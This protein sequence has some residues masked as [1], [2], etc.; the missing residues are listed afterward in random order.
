M[1][2]VI[3][4]Q[5]SGFIAGIVLTALFNYFFVRKRLKKIDEI[6][7]KLLHGWS[8]ENLCEHCFEGRYIPK[9]VE[10]IFPHDEWFCE[11]CGERASFSFEHKKNATKNI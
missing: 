11:K 9:R 10:D 5:I 4:D 8:P 3:I 7:E 1:L 2:N 6:E